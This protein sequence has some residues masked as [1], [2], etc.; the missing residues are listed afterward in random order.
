MPAPRVLGAGWLRYVAPGANETGRV[1]NGSF[2]QARDGR[3]ASRGVLPLGCQADLDRVLPVPRFALQGSYLSA[4]G[5]PGQ[6]VVMQFRS[7]GAAARYFAGLLRSL[8]ACAVPDG[9]SGLT[10]R[11]GAATGSSYSG[12]RIYSGTERWGELDLRTGARVTV[13]LSRQPQS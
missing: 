7:V 13:L 11:P 10:V 9:P 5:A 8:H 1:G 3:D 6:A 12:V 2:V 4:Q